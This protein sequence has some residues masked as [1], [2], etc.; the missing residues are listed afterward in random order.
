[1]RNKPVHALFLAAVLLASCAGNASAQVPTAFD[2]TEITP[3]NKN[4]GWLLEL[5]NDTI[6]AAQITL[7]DLLKIEY[8]YPIH[9]LTREQLTTRFDVVAKIDPPGVSDPVRNPKAQAFLIDALLKNHFH[10]KAHQAMI[11]VTTQQLI[12][13]PDN[14]K[15]TPSSPHCPCSHA[16]TVSSNHLKAER[17]LMP[18]LAAKLSKELGIEISDA[19]NLKGN[20]SIDLTWSTQASASPQPPEQLLRLT[21]VPAHSKE[22]GIMIDY[23]DLPANVLWSAPAPDSAQ[24]ALSSSH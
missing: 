9:G 6:A 3:A 1:M 23:V 22:L 11:D 18:V 15:L 20:Y 21:L 19:T 14:T 24:T 12:A 16:I 4:V 8:H 5:S 7:L 13:L 10:L 17:I 2:N